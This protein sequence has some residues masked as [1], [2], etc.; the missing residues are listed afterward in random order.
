MIVNRV[1]CSMNNDD[2]VQVCRGT[3]TVTGTNPNFVFGE[4]NDGEE[5]T[6]EKDHCDHD[7]EMTRKLENTEEGMRLDMTFAMNDAGDYWNVVF[8]HRF[9]F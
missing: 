9:D 5:F 8:M 1:V 2:P 7:S 3:L 6:I 4:S